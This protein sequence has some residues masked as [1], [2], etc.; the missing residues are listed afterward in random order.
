M[1]SV[2]INFVKEQIHMPKDFS[3]Y[4]WDSRTP[5]QHN[6]EIRNYYGWNKCNNTDYQRIRDHLYEIVIIQGSSNG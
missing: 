6:I 3:N 4:D 1:P 2:V 5:R